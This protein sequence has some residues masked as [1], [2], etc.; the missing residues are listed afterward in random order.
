MCKPVEYF[1]LNLEYIGLCQVTF[2]A[3]QKSLVFGTILYFNCYF[4]LEK[5][6]LFPMAYTCLLVSIYILYVSV[7]QSILSQPSLIF[8][9]PHDVTMG[10]CTHTLSLNLRLAFT[11]LYSF[12]V[13]SGGTSSLTIAA[14]SN[15]SWFI[16]LVSSHIPSGSFLI[17]Q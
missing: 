1:Y 4:F 11:Y 2:D 17:S 5:Y 7:L 9:A 14:T 3:Y 12:R 8:L 16:S 6:I 13:I 10:N 15:S